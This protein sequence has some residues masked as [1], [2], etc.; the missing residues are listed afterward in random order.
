WHLQMHSGNEDPFRFLDIKDSVASNPDL[1]KLSS[2]IDRHFCYQKPERSSSLEIEFG[3]QEQR[4]LAFYDYNFLR[5]MPVDTTED[6]LLA[7]S[8]MYFLIQK[9]WTGIYYLI[10]N[11][12][13][14]DP[15]LKDRFQSFLGHVHEKYCIHLGKWALGKTFK[16]T[17][18]F[19][20]NPL[21]DATIDIQN[22]WKVVIEMKSARPTREMLTKDVPFNKMKSFEQ[23]VSKLIHQ[24]SNRIDELRKSGYT[25]R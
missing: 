6:G 25:G 11:S 4:N 23:R 3:T 17:E 15:V 7:C 10:L 13:D 5:D 24:F 21:N 18:V 8:S 14:D 12:L 20:K 9:A 22:D 19:A 1:E 16:T 2:I